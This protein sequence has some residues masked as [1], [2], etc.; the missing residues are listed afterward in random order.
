VA[1]KKPAK[2]SAKQQVKQAP[3]VPAK[4]LTHE[5]AKKHVQKPVAKRAGQPTKASSAKPPASGAAPTPVAPPTPQAKAGTSKKKGTKSARTGTSGD[6]AKPWTLH[7]DAAAMLTRS[8]EDRVA[9]IRT[10]HWS[11]Y[12]HATGI[13]KAMEELLTYPRSH[14]MPN[15]LITGDTNNGKTFLLQRFLSKHPASDNPDGEAVHVPVLF[16]H[17][18][19]GP[20]ESRFYGEILDGLF[21]PFSHNDKPE[22]RE[23][24]VRSRLRAVGVRMLIVDELHNILAGTVT[25]QKRTLNAIRNLCNKSQ[26][27]LVGAGIVDARRAVMTDDQLANR[28][29]RMDLPRWVNDEGF[30]RLLVTLEQWLPFPERSMLDQHGA[31]LISKSEGL[32][33]E[34]ADF[35][36]EAAVIGVRA[37]AKCLT[38]KI[39]D[40]VDWTPP[41]ARRSRSES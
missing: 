22:A 4:K 18:P 40:Q 27:P 13:I 24:Q 1:A 30:A 37:G 11:P 19:S 5:W 34:V 7:P 33:G 9:F 31:Y 25:Q 3:K 36:K 16:V 2:T 6:A 12:D 23:A 41:S 29:K 35:L 28:F 17:M 21:A 39:F 32:L 8:V 15:L 20:D 10:P 14:R 26:I 38:E